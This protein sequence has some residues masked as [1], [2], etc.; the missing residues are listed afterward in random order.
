MKYSTLFLFSFLFLCTACIKDLPVVPGRMSPKVV[1][2]CLLTN[3]SVQHL[4]LTKSQEI[5]NNEPFEEIANATITLFEENRMVGTFT[6]NAY[7]QWRL[8]YTPVSGMSY[9]I[10]VEIDSKLTLK[11]STVMP[12]PTVIV[13]NGV[14]DE[15]ETKIFTQQSH[16]SVFWMFT[17][18][19]SL[20]EPKY[21]LH[22]PTIDEDPYHRLAFEIG[23]NHQD[24]DRF[25]QDGTASEFNEKYGNTLAYRHY[26]RI[27]PNP[28]ITGLT[29][30]TF[31]V[32]HR[33]RG[34]TFV[35]FHHVST[36]YDRYL[37]TVYE[38]KTFYENDDPVRWFDENSIYS[39][40][41]NG[42]GIFGAYVEEA[43]YYNNKIFFPK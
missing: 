2:T 32:Q 39:N 19:S 3:D 41:E 12:T 37:K 5:H 1:V 10:E 36:E 11:A 8:L 20:D 30:Y 42:L 28:V 22:P 25:N 9:R 27:T 43:F 21:Y 17:L 18:H 40:I 24:A 15:N 29:P 16:T 23:T 38:K 7:G 14:M 33:V 35:V 6:K 26:V 13:P 4:T 34:A 31:R